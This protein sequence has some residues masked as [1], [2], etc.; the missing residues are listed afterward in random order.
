MAQFGEHAKF[1]G[2]DS[3]ALSCIVSE[4]K[5]QGSLIVQSLLQKK[6]FDSKVNEARCFPRKVDSSL[7]D[8]TFNTAKG[9]PRNSLLMTTR[10]PKPQQLPN[11]FFSVMQ[12]TK[13]RQNIHRIQIIPHQ[14]HILAI[15]L[16][17]QQS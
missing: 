2:L 11:I 17:C 14:K 16:Q 12:L 15:T 8:V 10:S 3:N 5:E 6:L 13:H 9:T 1:V 4:S 7:V